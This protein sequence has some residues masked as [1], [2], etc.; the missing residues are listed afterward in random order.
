MYFQ[1]TLYTY[2]YRQEASVTLLGLYYNNFTLF[3]AITE[4]S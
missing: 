1:V 3:T 4:G 2:I